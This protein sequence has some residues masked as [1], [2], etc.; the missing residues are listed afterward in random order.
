MFRLFLHLL[1]GQ[2]YKLW[3][4]LLP[5]A[6]VSKYP[7]QTCLHPSPSHTFMPPPQIDGFVN[8]ELAMSHI[9]CKGG[10]SAN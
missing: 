2:L 9:S 4:S 7:T 3:W 1:D 10:M 5:S 6:A 8:P